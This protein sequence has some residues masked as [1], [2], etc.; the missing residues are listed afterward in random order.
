MVD[1]LRCFSYNVLY[2]AT[3]GFSDDLV[4]GSGGYGTV[5]AGE[6]RTSLLGITGMG[7]TT[8]VA[9]KML[10][11]ESLQG[12]DEFRAEVHS[13]THLRHPNIVPLYGIC[14]G[15]SLVERVQLKSFQIEGCRHHAR[16]APCHAQSTARV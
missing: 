5:H 8:E 2:R 3:N 10:D 9:I 7:P 6:L 12:E 4:I 1:G 14:R 13:L 16:K 15:V 11:S